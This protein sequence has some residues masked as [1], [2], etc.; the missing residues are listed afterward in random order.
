M[1]NSSWNWLVTSKLVV[2]FHNC[3][4]RGVKQM[5][6]T[7]IWNLSLNTNNNTN[8]HRTNKSRAN[9]EDLGI[10]LKL[11]YRRFNQR[12]ELEDGKGQYIS[13]YSLNNASDLIRMQNQSQ[14]WIPKLVLESMDRERQINSKQYNTATGERQTEAISYKNG[15]AVSRPFWYRA[16][17]FFLRYQMRYQNSFLIKMVSRYRRYRILS[18]IF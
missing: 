14:H 13:S 10:R 12:V 3:Y 15:I 4:E 2:V 1:N 18:P 5:K 9:K 8:S 11:C 17:L 16:I 6:G 7:R